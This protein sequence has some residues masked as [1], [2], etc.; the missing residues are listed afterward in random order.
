MREPLK[1]LYAR[2]SMSDLS[3][4][5]CQKDNP[6]VHWEERRQYGPDTATHI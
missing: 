4:T 1:P 2:L 3:G 5:N 6:H